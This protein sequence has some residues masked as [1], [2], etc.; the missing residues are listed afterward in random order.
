[1]IA[2]D[3]DG[4][5]VDTAEIVNFSLWLAVLAAPHL[6]DT[7]RR[8]VDVVHLVRLLDVW[9]AYVDR[10]DH[11][12]APMFEPV[13]Y[14]QRPGLARALRG[15]L[16]AWTPPVLPAEITAAARALLHAEGLRSPQGSWD[17]FILDADGGPAEDMLPWPEG[18]PML[19]DQVHRR[20]TEPGGRG[21]GDHGRD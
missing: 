10:G 6:Y 5:P 3:Q 20:G 12:Q 8:P 14:A 1:M 2:K 21:H 15:L 16:A 7:I 19:L 13:P 9:I 11:Y 18:V 4:M 17:A